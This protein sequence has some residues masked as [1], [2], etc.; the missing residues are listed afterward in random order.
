MKKIEN[1]RTIIKVHIA[2]DEKTKAIRDDINS[3]L[4]EGYELYDELK[5]LTENE[6]VLFYQQLVLYGESK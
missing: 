4:K 2:C 3:K 6:T 1:K 5:T